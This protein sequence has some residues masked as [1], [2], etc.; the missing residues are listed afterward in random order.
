[1]NVGLSK[2]LRRGGWPND[3]RGGATDSEFEQADAILD[4]VLLSWAAGKLIEVRNSV[5]PLGYRERR[6]GEVAASRRRLC[7]EWR[8]AI[9]EPPGS[10]QTAAKPASA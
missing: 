3:N 4:F 5:F 8:A 6:M 2:R 1:M 7:C 9:F 10:H